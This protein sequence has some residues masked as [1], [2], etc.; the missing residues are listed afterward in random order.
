METEFPKFLGEQNCPLVQ[1]TKTVLKY[2]EACVFHKSRPAGNGSGDTV[3]F[4]F[5]AGGMKV[6][7]C[8]KKRKEGE[9][10][11]WVRLTG[12]DQE[13]LAFMEEA[14]YYLGGEKS[15]MPKLL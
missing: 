11:T 7:Y 8:V 3:F 13:K 9:L 5:L 1:L 14:G 2:R 10:T 15:E 6:E 4:F 12:S